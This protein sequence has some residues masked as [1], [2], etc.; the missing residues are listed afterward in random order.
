MRLVD[1][2]KLN[3]LA[4]KAQLE[5]DIAPK[6]SRIR[7]IEGLI[8]SEDKINWNE[9]VAHCLGQ[10]PEPLTTEE[11]LKYIFYKRE[12]EIRNPKI[13]RIYMTRLSVALLRL[14]DRGYVHAETLEGCRVKVY[15]HPDCAKQLDFWYKLEK[16]KREII[17]AKTEFY[18]QNVY[19]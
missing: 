6:L 17:N 8:K 12:D 13:K 18:R 9:K 1:T 2:E 4:E 19:A 5:Q 16:K 3:L 10:I 14:C 15:A 11:I 7:Q